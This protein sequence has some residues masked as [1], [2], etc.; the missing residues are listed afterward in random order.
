M[1]DVPKTV[2]NY[3]NIHMCCYM[4][5]NKT[6]DKIRGPYIHI[7]EQAYVHTCNFD[8]YYVYILLPGIRLCRLL[9][10]E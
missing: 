5:L 3:E 1:Q 7:F 6:Y 2:F 8:M 10:E 9:L 4:Q